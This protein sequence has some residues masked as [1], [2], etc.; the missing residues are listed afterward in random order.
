MH[1]EAFTQWMLVA[2]GGLGWW[3]GWWSRDGGG[4][5][6]PAKTVGEDQPVRVVGVAGDPEPASVMQ[7]VMTRTQ[8]RQIPCVGRTG[9]VVGIPVDDVMDVQEPIGGAARRRD[10]RGHAG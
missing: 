2:A 10:S 4:V 3:P 6:H 9:A 5:H 8:T 7:P 1:L